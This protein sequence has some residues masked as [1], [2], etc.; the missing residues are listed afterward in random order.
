MYTFTHTQGPERPTKE[1]PATGHNRPLRVGPQGGAR[2]NLQG[3]QEL[4]P[5]PS[6]GR[7]DRKHLC[8]GPK[9]PTRDPNKILEDF[10]GGETP[11][12]S[13]KDQRNLHVESQILKGGWTV[14]KL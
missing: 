11:Y 5:G 3:L 2:I 4:H 9:G 6:W 14:D 12:L 8:E 1:A 7:R 10:L 13:V